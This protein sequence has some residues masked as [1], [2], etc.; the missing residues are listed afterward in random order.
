MDH[1]AL[2]TDAT[3]AF[4]AALADADPTAVVPACP[5]W[6]VRDLADHVGTV[7]QWARHAVLAGDPDAVTEP[8]PADAGA[9]D[10]ATWYA[11][12]ARTLVSALAEREPDVPAWTF[13]E[14]ATCAFW[15]RRQ[16]HETTMHLLDLHQA[17]ARG[18]APGAGPAAHR[19]GL[20][21]L[22]G[23]HP[24]GVALAADGIDEVVTMFWP[25]QVRLGRA[26]PPS[27]PLA[28]RAVDAGRTWL[29]GDP[30][31]SGA[32][33]APRAALSADAATLLLVLWRRL[34]LDAASVEGD[35]EVA[36]AALD[37]AVTP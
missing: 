20:P 5:P 3:A 34:P 8:A 28:L 9:A 33:E 37:R 21:G 14:P 24:A 26:V 27:A 32:P 7:H 11:G 31:A 2:L 36:A 29:L 23:P 16:V 22:L 4:A 1:L 17:A 15:R 6:R 12:H 13:A 35:P 18:A 19:R 30:T 10:L 25:R